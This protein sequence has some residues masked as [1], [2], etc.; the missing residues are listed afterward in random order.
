MRLLGRIR[1]QSVKS[2]PMVL[3]PPYKTFRRLFD[4]FLRSAIQRARLA[5][6]EVA[7]WLNSLEQADADGVFQNGVVVFTIVGQKP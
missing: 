4:G 7:A 3:R 5:E 6:A 1:F 2:M